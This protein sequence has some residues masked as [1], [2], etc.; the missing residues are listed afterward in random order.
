MLITLCWLTGALA[1]EGTGRDTQNRSDKCDAF[2]SLTSDLDDGLL[3]L[4]ISVPSQ[5]GWFPGHAGST[6]LVSALTINILL[7]SCPLS[8]SAD[9]HGTKVMTLQPN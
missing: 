6:N 7:A 8:S 2:V 4:L 5:G 9:S 1:N 3:C